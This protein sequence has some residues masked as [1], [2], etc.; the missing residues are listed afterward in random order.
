MAAKF[1]AIS[2]W[3]ATIWWR[4]RKTDVSWLFLLGQTYCRPRGHIK[5][6]SDVVVRQKKAT[7]LESI[8]CRVYITHS[9]YSNLE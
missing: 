1:V 2:I 4:N 5:I 3:A 7:H 6:G 8:T 9:M